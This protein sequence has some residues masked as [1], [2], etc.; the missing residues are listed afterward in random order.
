MLAHSYE[1]V[2]ATYALTRTTSAAGFDSPF[3]HNYGFVLLPKPQM[4]CASQCS[5][6]SPIVKSAT[7]LATRSAA[8]A[9]VTW[10]TKQS[11]QPVRHCPWWTCHAEGQ[12]SK[13][14][15]GTSR[16]A[17]TSFEHLCSFA[18]RIA[19]SCDILGDHVTRTEPLTD[20]LGA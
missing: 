18:A 20:G 2:N 13:V 6:S 1:S 14:T 5:V 4:T 15:Y 10:D 8:L 17:E 3:R 7:A 12:I 11:L 19:N 9:C 16:P